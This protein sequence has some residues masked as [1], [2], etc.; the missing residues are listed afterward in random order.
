LRPWLARIVVRRLTLGYPVAAWL[1]RAGRRLGQEDPARW[2]AGVLRHGVNAGLPHP[3]PPYVGAADSPLPKPPMV[4]VSLHVGAAG[5]FRGILEKLSAPTLVLSDASPRPRP[6]PGVTLWSIG[7][8]PSLR[9]MSMKRAL[10]EL[11]DGRFVFL[12][13]DR[14]EWS[15]IRATISGRTHRLARGPFVLARLAG[16]PVLPVAAR[17]Q[18]AKVQYTFGRPI[19]VADEASMAAAVAG[20]FDDYMSAHPD[21]LDAPLAAQFRRPLR[22]GR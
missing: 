17:W 15:G 6:R 22:G 9:L 3:Y 18:G 12:F 13:I 1:D 21:V 16:V 10:D 2:R 19:E 5:T 7:S 11:R 8:S 20:W 4:L 14:G